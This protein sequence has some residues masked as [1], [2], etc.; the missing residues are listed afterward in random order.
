MALTCDFDRPTTPREAASFSTRRVETPSRYDVA[1]TEASARSARRRCSRNAR[2]VRPVPQLRDGQLDRPGPGV[3]LPPPVAVAGVHPVRGHLPVPRVA[4]DLDVGVHHPLGELPDHRPQHIRA[5]RYQGLLELRAGNRH[6]VT[7][8]HFA[9]LRLELAISKDREVAASHHGDTPYSG[10]SVTSVPVTP[11]TTSVDVNPLDR[12]CVNAARTRTVPAFKSISL[13]VSAVTSPQRRRAT[14]RPSQLPTGA[15]TPMSSPRT[16]TRRSSSTLAWAFTCSARRRGSA[17]RFLPRPWPSPCYWPGGSS[18]STCASPTTPTRRS[19]AR[20]KQQA[21]PMTPC[22]DRRSWRPRHS[23]PAGSAA[24]TR[25][26]TGARRPH[27]RAPRPG[28]S[29]VPGLAGCG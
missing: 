24:E 12:R 13:R 25:Q 1:T 27:L 16:Y 14:T 22:S 18:S 5:R 7:C 23:F 15:S 6:N 10:N 21:K 17:I 28:L 3:P 20:C 9:L 29:G 4:A 11:Y 26:P 2:E 19:S 8:G